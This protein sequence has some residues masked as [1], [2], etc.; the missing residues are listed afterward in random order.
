MNA[1][2]LAALILFAICATGCVGKSVDLAPEFAPLEHLRESKVIAA[3]MN[4][5]GVRTIGETAYVLDIGKFMARNPEPVFTGMMRHER[6]HTIRQKKAGITKWLVK[7]GT[8]PDFMREEEYLGWYEHITYL[9]SK[10]VGINVDQVAK[11]LSGY[12]TILGKRM[13]SFD[14]AR[15]WAVAVL[16]GT[17]KPPTLSE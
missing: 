6:V 9:R 3:G 7:Y 16:N 1:K 11:I 2:L 8:D 10:G 12:K 13:V 4:D 15:A 14:K 17:W 5:S